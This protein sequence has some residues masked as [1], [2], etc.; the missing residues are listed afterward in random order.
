MEK[1]RFSFADRA[2]SFKYAGRGIARLISREHNAWI[3]C[4]VAV[5]VVVAG[6]LLG[7]S[8][9]EWVAVILCI[10]AV[11]AAEG[12][13]SAIE[14]LCDRVS[15]EYDE[16]IKHAKDL[17]AGAVLILAVMSVAVGLL[18]FIPKIV[19]LWV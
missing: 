1:K 7:L 11:L 17:A 6:A 2:R 3:H 19:A 5:C 12:I 16:A 10:G 15:T 8:S 18:I 9:L 13:N 14:A 4:F